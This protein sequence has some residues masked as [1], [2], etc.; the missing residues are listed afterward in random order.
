MQSRGSVYAK[1]ESMND[2]SFDG[3]VTWRK[4]EMEHEV[5]GD[6]GDIAFGSSSVWSDSAAAALLFMQTCRFT[7]SKN[8]YPVNINNQ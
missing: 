4:E 6:F 8:L 2:F 7:F 3:V 5:F 1:G